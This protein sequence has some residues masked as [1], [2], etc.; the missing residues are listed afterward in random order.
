MLT[1]TYCPVSHTLGLIGGKYKA[2][3][4]WRLMEG[5]QRYSQLRRSVPEATA[6]MLTQQLREME[7][8]GLIARQVYPVVPPRVEYSLTELGTSLKPILESIYTWG[9][10]ALLEKGHTPNCAMTGCACELRDTHSFHKPL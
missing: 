1:P 4:L 2:L 8:D 6:K 10:A 9:S 7:A 3:L 5:T